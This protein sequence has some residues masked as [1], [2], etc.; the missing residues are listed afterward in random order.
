M[1]GDRYIK[2]YMNSQSDRQDR[3]RNACGIDI[4]LQAIH[5]KAKSATEFEE[6]HE[7]ALVELLSESDELY[8][9]FA[10]AVAHQARYEAG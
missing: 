5:K 9:A 2:G 6:A 10:D 4:D 8:F 1:E 3:V 7:A